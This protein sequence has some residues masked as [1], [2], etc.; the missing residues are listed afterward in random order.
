MQPGESSWL[1]WPQ[2]WPPWEPLFTAKGCLT[3]LRMAFQPAG[4]GHPLWF[5]GCPH[6]LGAGQ[7]TGPPPPSCPVPCQALQVLVRSLLLCVALVGGCINQGAAGIY[8]FLKSYGGGE[9]G[10]ACHVTRTGRSWCGLW[11][12]VIAMASGKH[13]LGASSWLCTWGH[14]GAGPAWWGEPGLTQ[15][16]CSLAWLCIHCDEAEQ[17]FGPEP[18]APLAACHAPFPSPVAP[19]R[20]PFL[21]GG[22][23]DAG[24]LQQPQV[25]ATS[26][27]SL[28]GSTCR[29]GGCV[30]QG[31]G[32]TAWTRE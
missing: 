28:L 3:N 12:A 25:S 18:L 24:L 20:H 29:A 26:V 22:R 19:G 21:Q 14:N 27:S 31:F 23:G 11:P 15:P 5:L 30:P 1:C 2:P 8:S 10:G 32:P 7:C 9:I 16:K 13:P 17:L 4:K 6:A